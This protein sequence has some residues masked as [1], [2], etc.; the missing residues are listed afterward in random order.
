MKL[1]AAEGI[2]IESNDVVEINGDNVH[3]GDGGTKDVIILPAGVLFL[4]F[5][6]AQPEHWEG[7]PPPYVADALNRLAAALAADGRKP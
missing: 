7:E 4:K 6:A 3:I 1:R 5:R 2:S